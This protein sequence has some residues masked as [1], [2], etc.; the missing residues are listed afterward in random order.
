MA[1]RF[2]GPAAER[3][4]AAGPKLDMAKRSIVGLATSSSACARLRF[5]I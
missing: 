2:C 4:A 5:S 3:V 1:W